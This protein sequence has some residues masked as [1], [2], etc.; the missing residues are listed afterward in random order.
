MSSNNNCCSN[1]SLRS[2]SKPS[3]WVTEVQ[4]LRKTLPLFAVMYTVY[5]VGQILLGWVRHKQKLKQI[6]AEKDANCIEAESRNLELELRTQLA[7][8]TAREAN[9]HAEQFAQQA[10][11]ANEQA[12]E[13]R[14]RAVL[15]EEQVR[16]F[17][18]LQEQLASARPV[19]NRMA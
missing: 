15:A 1:A 19:P 11:D 14:R 4:D 8:A 12:E 2:T 5:L 18:L 10:R 6:H 16:N 9:S 13:F 7:E 17:G 3:S